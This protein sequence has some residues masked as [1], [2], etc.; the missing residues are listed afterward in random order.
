[1]QEAG[2]HPLEVIQAATLNGAELVGLADQIGSLV[3]GK[4]ADIV[5]VRENPIRNFKV[6]YG[7]GH[8][9]LNPETGE[10]QRVGG[11]AYTI[12]DGI[13]YDAQAL[14]GDVRRMVAEET[15]VELDEL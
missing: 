11:V 14:L 7:T 15:Q 6:L 8:M 10:L 4:R 12:K 3:P 13:V 5:L 1:M 9:R 2:F